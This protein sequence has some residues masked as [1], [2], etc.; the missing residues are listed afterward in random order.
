MTDEGGTTSSAAGGRLFSPTSEA[1]VTLAI[2]QAFFD[3]FKECVSSDVIVVGGG[4]SG[5]VAARD[6][7]LKGRSVVVLESNNALGGG[8]W[9]GGYLMN[10]L[11]VRDPAHRYLDEIG[12]PYKPAGPEGLYVASAPHACSRLIAAACDSGVKI[13]NMTTFDDVVLYENDRVGGV[14]INWS[15]IR[16]LPKGMAALDPVSLEAKVVI[17]ATGHDAHVVRSMEKHGILKAKGEGGMWIDRS[18]DVVVERTGLIH[19]GLIITG[20][21]VAAYHGLPR[22]GPVFGSMFLSGRRAAEAA[23]EELD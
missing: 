13:L 21:A 12:V 10:K 2:A 23:L 14:V 19:P 8:F 22:M 11:T 15:P 16:A 3:M 17:D 6:L 9:V 20:M 4:P 18:E 5:C 1:E 7:A